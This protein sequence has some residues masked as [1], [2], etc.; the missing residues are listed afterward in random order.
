MT[1][2][3]KWWFKFRQIIPRPPGGWVVCGPYSTYEEAKRARE[4]AKA[5]DAEVT[6]PFSAASKDE[7][8]TVHR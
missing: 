4:S 5:Y 1:G 3:A 2:E 6:V 8:E 7:A